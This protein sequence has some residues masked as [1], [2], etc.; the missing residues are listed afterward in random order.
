[1][2]PIVEN[3]T[4]LHMTENKWL[5]YVVYVSGEFSACPDIRKSQCFFFTIIHRR[6]LHLYLHSVVF[7]LSLYKYLFK[8]IKGTIL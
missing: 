6:Y 8:L 7:H 1:M 3:L 2:V 4:G 5:C